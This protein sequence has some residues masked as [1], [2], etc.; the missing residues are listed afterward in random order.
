[1]HL[2]AHVSTAFRS[3]A[4][5]RK[6]A[7]LEVQRRLVRQRHGERDALDERVSVLFL[8]HDRL[9]EHDTEL[10]ASKHADQALFEILCVR[11][12]LRDASESEC[13]RHPVGRVT[14]FFSAWRI[15]HPHFGPD[16]VVHE[17]GRRDVRRRHDEAVAAGNRAAR[18]QGQVR[19]HARSD[20]E[21]LFQRRTVQAVRTALVLLV[22]PSLV[23]LFVCSSAP[24]RQRKR[25]GT[26]PNDATQAF[27]RPSLSGPQPNPPPTPPTPTSFFP[28]YFARPP[29]TVAAPAWCCSTCCP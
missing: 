15:T 20:D 21:V 12:R 2:A 3:V 11:P 1:M 8:L 14:A 17:E 28:A 10:F 6:H 5:R 25:Y 29:R 13:A 16:V 18:G 9:H 4:K 27:S 23:Y 7:D 22:R 19:L 26:E 24:T